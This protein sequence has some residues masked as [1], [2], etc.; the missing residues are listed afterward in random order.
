[1]EKAEVVLDIA[2]VP[3]IPYASMRTTSVDKIK[4]SDNHNLMAFTVDIMNDE[5][6][7]GGVKDLEKNEYLPYFVFKNVHTMEFGPGENPRYLYYTETTKEDNRPWRVMRVDLQTAAV[8]QIYHDD[9]P[10]HYVDL[11]TTKDKKY[12]I[13]SSNTKEDSEILVLPRDEELEK[14]NQAPKLIVPRISEMRS[15]IDHIRDFFVTITTVSPEDPTVRV[16]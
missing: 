13:I 9:D 6:M 4:L 3:F 5:V 11:G 15:H 12:L 2:D 16:A 8:K 14:Q 7:T 1:M 10:T